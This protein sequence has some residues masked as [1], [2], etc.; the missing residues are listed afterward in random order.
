MSARSHSMPFAS[1]LAHRSGVSRMERSTRVSSGALG[2]LPRPRFGVSSC[3]MER[4]VAPIIGD[5]RNTLHSLFSVLHLIHQQERYMTY[6][7]KHK[8][9]GKFFAGF[10]ANNKPVWG[11]E[12]AAKRMDKDAARQQALLFRCFD[13]RVQSK[14]VAL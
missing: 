8:E 6:T 7:V 9:S 11:N 1:I 4:T 14:P 10:D 12:Q 3:V 13:L 5:T 2:G